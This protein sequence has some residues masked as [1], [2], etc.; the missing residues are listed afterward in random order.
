M[1]NPAM[2]RGI[3]GRLKWRLVETVDLVAGLLLLGVGQG[4]FLAA[5]MLLRP[6]LRTPANIFLAALVAGLALSCLDGALRASGVAVPVWLALAFLALLPLFGPLLRFH[7]DALLEEGEWRIARRHTKWLLSPA[8]GTAL[9]IAFPFLAGSSAGAIMTDGD[10]PDDPGVLAAVIVF[11]SVHVLA[12]LQQGAAMIWG[13]RSTNAVRTLDDATRSRLIWLRGLLMLALLCWL[14]YVASLVAGLVDGGVAGNVEYWAS[15]TYAGALYGLGLLG[16]ARPDTLLPAP[17]QIVAA[18]VKPANGPKY[19]K[20][21]LTD[22]DAQRIADKVLEAFRRSQPHL[23]PTI[24]LAKLAQLIGASTNDV[25]QAINTQLGGS[26]NDL[27]SRWRI[28]EAKRLLADPAA[29]ESVLD[30]C[31]AVGF[32][33]KS[34]FNSA[35]KRFTGE[36]PSGFRSRCLV[37]SE[38]PAN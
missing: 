10:V 18:I 28:E 8:L 38:P 33:S 27:I 26:Y 7:L 1:L 11:L 30:V 14:A 6:Q 9:V 5:L 16:L 12:A 4:L 21:A 32:N 13:M 15:L 37:S 3:G 2:R 36:T 29:S 34:V 20:S 17:G 35:F 22:E 31:Y 24:T 25:S 19:A 23:D